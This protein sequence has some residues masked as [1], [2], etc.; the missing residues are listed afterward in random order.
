MP[1][2]VTRPLVSRRQ[3][4]HMALV[5]ITKKRGRTVAAVLPLLTTHSSPKQFEYGARS[6]LFGQGRERIPAFTLR[7][8]HEVDSAV[9][10]PYGREYDGDDRLLP[11]TDTF[12]RSDYIE[13]E[14]G[15]V[16]YCSKN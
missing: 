14:A 2:P 4:R 9:E 8:A 13:S 3:N 6:G 16:R 5:C 1:I 7:I 11:A 10:S 15:K 12:Q